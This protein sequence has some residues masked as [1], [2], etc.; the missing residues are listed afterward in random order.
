MFAVGGLGFEFCLFVVGWRRHGFWSERPFIS[1]YDFI[2]FFMNGLPVLTK[3]CPWDQEDGIDL[4]IDGTIIA[5][6]AISIT[7]IIWFIVFYFG[8]SYRA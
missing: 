2:H 8:S 5:I 7:I 1:I 4:R 3:G 6:I